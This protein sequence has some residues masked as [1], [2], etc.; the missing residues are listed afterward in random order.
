MVASL[1]ALA[2]VTCPY[3]NSKVTL[4]SGGFHLGSVWFLGLRAQNC[5]LVT[6]TAKVL[7]F[8]QM[9]ILPFS[10]TQAT[11]MMQSP[12]YDNA[13]IEWWVPEECPSRPST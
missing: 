13:T 7:S 8:L 2:K 11:P 10:L 1:S 12:Q 9:E 3:L 6:L 5:P 4:S